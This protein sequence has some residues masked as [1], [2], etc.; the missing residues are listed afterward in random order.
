MSDRPQGELLKGQDVEIKVF[1]DGNLQDAITDVSE[2]TWEDRTSVQELQ[3]LG[4]KAPSF[5]DVY[6]G[7]HISWSANSSKKSIFKLMQYIRE[8][9]AHITPG[10][11]F[12]AAATFNFPSGER[13]RV[14]FPNLSWD[15][16]TVSVANR[17]DAAQFR[18]GASCSMPKPVG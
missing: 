13:Q 12:Q 7:A 3:F 4:R 2:F 14:L 17:A 9:A 16:T 8:R 11:S 15:A 10:L 18:M 1:K 6:N 5:S